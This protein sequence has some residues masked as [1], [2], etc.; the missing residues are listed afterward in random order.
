M[1]LKFMDKLFGRKNNTTQSMIQPN[2]AL[3]V[4]NLS[5]Y[6][7]IITNK[8]TLGYKG[9]K[10]AFDEKLEVNLDILENNGEH[11]SVKGIISHYDEKYEQLLVVTGSNLK[12]VVFSQIND[13]KIESD[14]NIQSVSEQEEIEL[15]DKNA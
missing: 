9:L 7:Q 11:A 2:A 14:N 12:R 10:R 15:D 4:N 6:T 3:N 8:E 5:E 13:V 1:A